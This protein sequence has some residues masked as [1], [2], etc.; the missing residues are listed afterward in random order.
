VHASVS[1]DRLRV[2]EGKDPLSELRRLCLAC[3]RVDKAEE[4]PAN[5]REQL[6]ASLRSDVSS[7]AVLAA[8]AEP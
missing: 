6:E 8:A 2:D 3:V 4:A 7:R 1:G 5:W